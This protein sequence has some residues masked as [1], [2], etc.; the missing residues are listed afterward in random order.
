MKRDRS[1]AAAYMAFVAAFG[2]SSTAAA[3]R[4]E[5]GAKIGANISQ[6]DG[7]SDFYATYLSPANGVL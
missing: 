3:Q 2:I 4:I 6:V 5:L 7:V 1:R